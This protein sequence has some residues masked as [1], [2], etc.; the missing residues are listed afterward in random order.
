MPE[1]SVP[2][3]GSDSVKPVFVNKYLSV[4]D[5]QYAPGAHYFDATRRTA[6]DIAAIKSDCDFKKMLPDAVTCVVIIENGDAEP[7][8]LLNYEYRYPCGRFLLSPPAGLIDYEDKL[9]PEPLLSAAAR[10]IAEET[11]LLIGENDTLKVISPLLFSSPGMTDESN[12]LVLAVLRGND[13]SG[14]G[15]GGATGTELFEEF[16]FV[17]RE[18]ALGILKNGRDDNG[19]YFSAYT[20]LALLTFLNY[21]AFAD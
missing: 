15:H 12:G 19:N 7:V 17:D 5:L 20:Q 8:L 9:T 2:E 13:L 16:V 10:E 11:G 4:Y 3:I 18:K 1:K 6:D 21:G 14:L